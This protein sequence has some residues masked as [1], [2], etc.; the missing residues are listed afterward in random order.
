[1]FN[2]IAH[3]NEHKANLSRAKKA[4][5]NEYGH[6]NTH[7]CVSSPTLHKRAAKV[8]YDKETEEEKKQKR[9]NMERS[10]VGHSK[11]V[12]ETYQYM[13]RPTFPKGCYYLQ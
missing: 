9:V 12:P 13:A 1:M 7:A 2:L 4:S 8:K 10:K 11:G 3:P 5:S 6:S